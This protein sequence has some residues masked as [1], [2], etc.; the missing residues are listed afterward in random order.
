MPGTKY[1]KF[2]IEELVKKFPKQEHVESLLS[3]V[4]GIQCLKA[5]R[6]ANLFETAV[7]E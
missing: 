4:S 2:Y 1:D 5:G 3:A 7:E 6:F